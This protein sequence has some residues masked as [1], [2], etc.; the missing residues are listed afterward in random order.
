MCLL[1]RHRDAFALVFTAFATRARYLVIFGHGFV[2][3]SPSLTAVCSAAHEPGGRLLRRHRPLDSLK[4]CIRDTQM[5]YFPRV[6]S[7]Y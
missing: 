1:N 6:L 5:I 4:T 3:L 7:A 2:V